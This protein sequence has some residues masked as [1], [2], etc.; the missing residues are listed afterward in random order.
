[1]SSQTLGFHQTDYVKDQV[2]HFSDPPYSIIKPAYRPSIPE[3]NTNQINTKHVYS[4]EAFGKPKKQR[5]TSDMFKTTFRS[6]LQHDTPYY[7]GTN[8]LYNA[9][10]GIVDPSHTF[11][12]PTY[13][14]ERRLMDFK[15]YNFKN[16]DLSSEKLQHVRRETFD[17]H[18]KMIL[19]LPERRDYIGEEV[20]SPLK[21][22]QVT[23]RLN[24][25]FF[26]QNNDRKIDTSIFGREN[27]LT[28]PKN[29]VGVASYKNYLR[30]GHS[31][32]NRSTVHSLNNR[33]FS[34]E[35]PLMD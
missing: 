15:N 3:P 10:Q 29:S 4:F 12:H 9:K 8:G 31:R 7:R 35:A 33:S 23:K 21:K 30:Q 18:G 17:I 13:H 32:Q 2:N 25:Q 26:N 34:H 14:K 1:M 27:Y 11:T 6:T 5:S 28:A 22:Y 20:V 24:E 19:R 16:R